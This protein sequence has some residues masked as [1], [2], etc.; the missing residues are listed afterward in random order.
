MRDEIISLKER[1]PPLT[2]RNMED[3]QQSKRSD[4][5]GRRE[6]QW[7][8]VAAGRRNICS[9]TWHSE[10]KPIPVIHNRYEV[11]NNCYI[12]EYG[13]SDPY[14]RHCPNECDFSRNRNLPPCL[15]NRNLP[16]HLQQAQF[17][18]RRG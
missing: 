12:S 17:K 11:L 13:N 3:H 1:R 4:H 14:Q 16:P 10:S 2:E 9:H 7:S 8:E 15:Q 5:M 6:A 18:D